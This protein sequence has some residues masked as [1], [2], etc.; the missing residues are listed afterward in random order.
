VCED[1][2]GDLTN[3]VLAVLLLLGLWKLSDAL[4]KH[5]EEKVR[6]KTV[7]E[8]TEMCHNDGYISFGKDYYPI[9]GTEKLS[10]F[11]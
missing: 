8:L 1:L 7:V 4:E 6:A 2:K 11:C 5:T 9:L 10:F 3:K